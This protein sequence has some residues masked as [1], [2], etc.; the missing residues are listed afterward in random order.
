MNL[1]LQALELDGHILA[2]KTIVVTPIM[3]TGASKTL[4]VKNLSC[5]TTKSDVI[6]FLKEVGEIADVR[7]S[8]REDG[9]FRGV[10]H[11]EFATD[12]AAKKATEFDGEYL[13]GRPVKLGFVRETIFIRGFDTSSGI[14]QIRSSL[15]EHFSTCG[16]IL[17]MH[18]P[19]VRETDAPQGI[20]FIE[21]LHPEAFPKALAMNGHKLGRFPLDN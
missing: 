11:I 20:A 7:F 6:E 16:K 10:C 2:S 8:A 15:E 19:T 18:V 5:S 14:N 3:G 4:C 9:S 21:F 1:P 17:W 13:L 12:E